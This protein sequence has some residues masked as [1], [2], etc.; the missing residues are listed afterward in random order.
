MQVQA[1]QN[2]NQTSFGAIYQPKNID[3][4]KVQE[5]I[6]EAIKSYKGEKKKRFWIW[7]DIYCYY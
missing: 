6:A 1:V 3:F 7:G 5:P 2:N 4:N